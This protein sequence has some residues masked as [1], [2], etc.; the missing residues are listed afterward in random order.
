M[1]PVFDGPYESRRIINGVAYY[2]N[3]DRPDEEM[4][5]GVEHLLP[6]RP[7]RISE[8]WQDPEE[9]PSEELSEEL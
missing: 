1:L 5:I 9:V 2:V 6:V 3:P 8:I 4:Q 7:D